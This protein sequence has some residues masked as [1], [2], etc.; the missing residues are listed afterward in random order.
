MLH[1]LPIPPHLSPADLHP[2]RPLPR[3]FQLYSAVHLQ[4]AH[5]CGVEAGLQSGCPVSMTTRA[6]R[7]CLG[8]MPDSAASRAAIRAS[9]AAARCSSAAS[10]ASS[11]MLG[12]LQA[13][14]DSN[15]SG[16]RCAAL[17]NDQEPERA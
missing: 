5:T 14:V 2:A 3:L 8:A 1:R 12:R 15:G 13:V 4:H 9:A 7:M 6:G 16:D 11:P 17:L 10:P